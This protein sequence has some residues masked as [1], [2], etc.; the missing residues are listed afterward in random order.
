MQKLIS[1]LVN[2]LHNSFGISK[3]GA[4]GAIVAVFT[5]IAGIIAALAV[6]AIEGFITRRR[7]RNLLKINL[8]NLMKGL[9]KQAHNCKKLSD[10][11]II[12]HNGPYGLSQGTISATRI[13]YQLGYD[14]LHAA[15]FSGLENTRIFNRKRK[16]IAFNNIW[17]T[18]EFVKIFYPQSFKRFDE[19]LEMNIELNNIRNSCLAVVSRIVE[20]IRISLDGETV[21]ADLHKYFMA[22]ETIVSDL[23]AMENYT[24]AK[25]M[26]EQYVKKLL[27]VLRSDT[28]M[29]KK[30]AELLRPVDLLMALLECEH[31]YA[32]QKNLVDASHSSFA[33]YNRSFLE[34]YKRMQGS[35]RVLFHKKL[36]FRKLRVHPTVHPS[37]HPSLKSAKKRLK[38]GF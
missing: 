13:F 21:Q 19:F 35:Y 12:E 10:Q 5:F 28:K 23:R 9:Y 26:D 3:D 34:N 38:T 36:F 31:A 20:T 1:D 8:K 27:V 25:I 32:N 4:A 29:L 30:Y 16:R 7:N 37:V 6:K 14:N 11:L 17:G 15:V 24:N 2:F 33:E 22:I 18:L